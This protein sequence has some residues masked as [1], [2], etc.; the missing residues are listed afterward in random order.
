M[1][2]VFALGWFAIIFVLAVILLAGAGVIYLIGRP[3]GWWDS[4][5][6][7][8]QRAGRKAWLSAM[9]PTDRAAYFKHVKRMR[10]YVAL[11]QRL[12]VEAKRRRQAAF[13]RTGDDS[14]YDTIPNQL[15]HEWGLD[16]WEDMRTAPDC[17]PLPDS[18]GGPI[19][20]TTRGNRYPAFK[21]PVWR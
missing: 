10:Q 7:A 16:S 6:E 11:R 17:P 3:L 14:D 18:R 15:W 21:P 2:W 19:D 8:E 4:I 5:L 20:T 9:T 1:I 12:F 13:D